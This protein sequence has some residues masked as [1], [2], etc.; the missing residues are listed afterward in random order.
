[1]QV[2]N[3]M[4]RDQSHFAMVLLGYSSKSSVPLLSPHWQLSGM[5]WN[6]PQQRD[7]VCLGAQGRWGPCT[8]VAITILVICVLV[9]LIKDGIYWD[10]LRNSEKK[11]GD[12]TWELDWHLGGLGSGEQTKGH[13]MGRVISASGNNMIASWP[14]PLKPFAQNIKT[15]REIWSFVHESIVSHTSMKTPLSIAFRKCRN[16]TGGFRQMCTSR[17]SFLEPWPYR[18][19]HVMRSDY[20]CIHVGILLVCSLNEGYAH[21]KLFHFLFCRGVALTDCTF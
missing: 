13:T 21:T 7:N 11:L 5:S 14:L 19:Q 17:I 15:G 12:R 3:W 4:Y 6:Q 20:K 16:F 8:S 2:S 9:I 18:N 1:M 10:H